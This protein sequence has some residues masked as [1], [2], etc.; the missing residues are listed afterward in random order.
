MHGFWQSMI[1]ALHRA[2]SLMVVFAV[3]VGC[4]SQSDR[5]HQFSVTLEG[6][7]RTVT[8]SGPPLYQGEI[9]RYRPSTHMSEDERRPESLLKSPDFFTN[10]GD[11][12]YVVVD[13]APGRRR[14]VIFDSLGVFKTSFGRE[15]SAPGEFRS[16]LLVGTDKNSLD[17][18]DVNLQRLT[19]YSL[20]GELLFV[21]RIPTDIRHRVS[22]A[23]HV[24]TDTM[25]VSNDFARGAGPEFSQD[26]LTVITNHGIVFDFDSEPLQNKTILDSGMPTQAPYYEVP[27]P[28][29]VV[30]TYFKMYGVIHSP[31]REPVLEVFDLAGRLACRI[32]LLGLDLRT[33]NW[34]WNSLENIWS[35]RIARVS[36][37]NAQRIARENYGQL[38]DAMPTTVAAWD[39]VYIDDYGYYWLRVPTDPDPWLSGLRDYRF[40][41]LSPDGEYLGTTQLPPQRV[42]SQATNS[43]APLSVANGELTVIS[44]DPVSGAW[45][46]QAYRIESTVKGLHYP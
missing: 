3:V 34:H 25:V 26:R 24:N 36:N 11:Q 32:E 16:M 20:S 12:G 7:S 27:F 10:V 22:S 30:L 19:R 1:T 2:S 39:Y 29:V 13:G 44:K 14:I 31:G 18:F 4:S 21:R 17:I 33:N 37:S 41:L 43:I 28:P 8:N 40:R 38:R 35:E 42:R 9:L 5:V 15:G 6:N 45:N 46:L 23:F